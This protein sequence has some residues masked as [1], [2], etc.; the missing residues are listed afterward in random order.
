MANVIQAYSNN[1]LGVSIRTI[2]CGDETRF[3]ARDVIDYLS[4]DHT[5]LR[6]LDDD[7]KGVDT[8]PT[9]GGNQQM[10]IVTEPGL[11]K[12]IM[13]S[14]KPEAKAFQRWVT[15]E[16]LPSIRRQGGYMV[17]A[18]DETPEQT[19]ARALLIA[20]DALKKKDARIAE[21]EPKGKVFDACLAGDR[22]YTFTDASHLLRQT[23]GEITRTKL[24][25]LAIKDNIITVDH[26]ATRCGIDR[27][28]VVDYIPPAGVNQR[29]GEP[30]PHKQYAK[31][32]TKGLRW[33][34][35]RYCQEG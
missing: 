27:G 31:I 35:K 21:L 12:L 19:M 29:T 20:N 26:R 3:V 11:Y 7:E 15:H 32:T 10:S 33:M 24:F 25:G 23:N 9:L 34:L 22:W 17:A 2:S 28:Y 1:E 16:V 14:R 4:L 5:A 6:K 8:I 13:K 18:A 30:I